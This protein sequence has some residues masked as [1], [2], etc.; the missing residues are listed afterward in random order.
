MFLY[1]AERVG[2]GRFALLQPVLVGLE[3][4]T[5]RLDQPL[6]GFLA[7]HQ[8]ALGGFLKFREGFVGQTQKLRLRLPQRV[9][10]QGFEGIAQIRQRPRLDFL[11]LPQRL[12]MQ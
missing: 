5:E 6:D 3:L 9:G 1:L 10:A 7:L 4:L 11:R 12:V 2:L 8:I